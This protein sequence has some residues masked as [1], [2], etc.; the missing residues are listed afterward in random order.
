MITKLY[1]ALF[2]MCLVSSYS[3][4]QEKM[5]LTNKGMMEEQGKV[6][7]KHAKTMM[8]HGKDLMNEGDKMMKAGMDMMEGKASDSKSWALE[9][10]LEDKGRMMK[11]RADTIWQ[12]GD[13][14]VK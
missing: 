6:M 1:M 14:M 8:E 9:L 5:D 12:H 11:D 3:Y 7:M 10:N 13:A 4:A 2:L